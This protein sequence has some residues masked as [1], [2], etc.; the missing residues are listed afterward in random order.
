MDEKY[1]IEQPIA[2]QILSNSINSN[3]FF[4]AYLF[5]K[6]DYENYYNFIIE[7]V[8]NV[9]CPNIKNKECIKCNIC[10]SI[11]KNEY[12]EL[13][14][15]NPDGQWIKKSQ[16]DK[17]Q[18][19]FSKKNIIGRNKVYIIDDADKLNSSAANSILKFLEEPNQNIIGVLIAKTSDDVLQT[20]VSRCQIISL[21]NYMNFS[22]LSLHEKIKNLIKIDKND[23]FFYQNDDNFDK[24]LQKIVNFVLFLE[25]SNEKTICYI[26]QI[27]PEIYEKENFNIIMIIILNIYKDVLYTK[28]DKKMQIFSDFSQKLDEICQKNTINSLIKKI[29]V[30]LEIQDNLKYNANLNLSIDKFIIE[31][32]R[33]NNNE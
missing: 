26:Y 5:E 9:I 10:N 1:K 8:K 15:I 22:E 32:S 12:I 28:I 31:M 14:V 25:K 2:Y 11:D 27:I 17:L 21:R 3:K 29:S 23:A 7:F 16:I 20:I 33:C 18:D 24:N 30:I 6:N 19:E 4:H 13:K